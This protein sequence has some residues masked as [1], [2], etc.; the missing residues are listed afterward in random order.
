MT[1]YSDL[2][3]YPRASFSPLTQLLSSLWVF[4]STA[5][6]WPIKHS[7]SPKESSMDSEAYTTEAMRNKSKSESHLKLFMFRH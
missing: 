2:R 7:M 5:P 3:Q 6:L 4:L 1:E